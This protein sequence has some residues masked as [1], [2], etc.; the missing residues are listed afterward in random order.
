[1]FQKVDEAG[2]RCHQEP[3]STGSVRWDLSPRPPKALST[4]SRMQAQALT[5]GETTVSLE[6]LLV[7]LYSNKKR[8]RVEGRL[9]LPGRQGLLQGNAC[10]ILYLPCAP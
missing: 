3:C 6:G 10:L 8:R 1:M 7:I 5:R 2:M 4:P 9:A